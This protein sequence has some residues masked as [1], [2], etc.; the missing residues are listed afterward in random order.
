MLVGKKLQCQLLCRHWICLRD[1]EGRFFKAKLVKLQVHEGEALELY[2]VRQ[3]L[4][5]MGLYH[6]IFELNSKVT[7]D[8]LNKHVPDIDQNLGALYLV[9]LRLRIPFI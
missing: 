8:N 6:R 9:V 7:V 5:D 4:R 1:D 3:W 2:H